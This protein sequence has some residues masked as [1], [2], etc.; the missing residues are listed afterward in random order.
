[1]RALL[2]GFGD[3]REKEAIDPNRITKEDMIMEE[4]IPICCSD[5]NQILNGTFNGSE[6]KIALG[7][8]DMSFV[9]SAPEVFTTAR[10]IAGVSLTYIQSVF[11]K[12]QVTEEILNKDQIC[13]IKIIS[14]DKRFCLKSIS[15]NIGKK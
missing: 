14:S 10:S 7:N 6:S 8:T 1:M 3:I 13:E 4:I 2:S 11:D 12:E 5:E 15:L 9:V